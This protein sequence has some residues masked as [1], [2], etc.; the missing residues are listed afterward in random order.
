MNLPLYGLLVQFNNHLLFDARAFNISVISTLQNLY[1]SA[2]SLT[3]GDDLS[4]DTCMSQ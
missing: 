3:L 4:L 1:R 2:L